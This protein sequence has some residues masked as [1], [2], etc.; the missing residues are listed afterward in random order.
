ML[1]ILWIR[2]WKHAL[3]VTLWICN[4]PHSARAEHLA[5][6]F[7]LKLWVEPLGGGPCL[8]EVGSVPAQGLPWCPAFCALWGDCGTT[9]Y[10]LPCVSRT[11]IN[12]NLWMSRTLS[13]PPLDPE[14]PGSGCGAGPSTNDPTGM[15]RKAHILRSVFM[16]VKIEILKKKILLK[17]LKSIPWNSPIHFPTYPA[18]WPDTGWWDEEFFQD[19]A[20]AASE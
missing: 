9:C 8:A 7:I 12:R 18:I 14:M 5:P 4:A 11:I 16:I 13:F 20:P 19:P 15:E 1:N 10:L 2:I 6:N 17:N 3:K